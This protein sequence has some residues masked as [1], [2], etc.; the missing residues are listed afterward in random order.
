M[1]LNLQVATSYSAESSSP[2]S[3]SK[4]KFM[5]MHSVSTFSIALVRCHKAGSVSV[6]GSWRWS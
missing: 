4:E 2:P 1:P 6:D 5:P 3:C